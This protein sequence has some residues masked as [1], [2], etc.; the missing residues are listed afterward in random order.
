M[1]EAHKGMN[2][3]DAHFDAVAGHFVSTLQELGVDQALIDEAVAVVESTRG[4]VLG[5]EQP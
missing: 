4:Q 1:Y 5:A 3:K 2:L